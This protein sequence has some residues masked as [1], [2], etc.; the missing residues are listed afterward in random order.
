VEKLQKTAEEKLKASAEV[1]KSKADL[2]SK[3]SAL[4]MNLQVLGNTELFIL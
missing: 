3:A 4:E 1:E 2:E